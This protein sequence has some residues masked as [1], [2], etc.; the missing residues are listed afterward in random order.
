MQ[1]ASYLWR[2]L[3]GSIR[4]PAGLDVTSKQSLIDSLSR[5]HGEAIRSILVPHCNPAEPLRDAADVENFITWLAL[6]QAFGKDG[7]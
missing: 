6:R 5:L 1:I 3:D 7:S 2:R 4:I